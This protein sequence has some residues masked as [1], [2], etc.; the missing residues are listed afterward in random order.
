MG[1]QRGRGRQKLILRRGG[2]QRQR[3]LVAGDP[4]IFKRHSPGIG[5]KA[6]QRITVF[7]PVARADAG[8]ALD[9]ACFETQAGLDFRVSTHRAGT[10]CP[11]P[12]VPRQDL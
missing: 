7:G 3:D 5:G 11:K 9:P 1:K 10:A 4:G 6:A 2:K 12:A 8:P